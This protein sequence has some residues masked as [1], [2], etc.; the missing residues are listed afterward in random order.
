[1]YVVQFFAFKTQKFIRE[2][3]FIVL[4]VFF[5]CL[6]MLQTVQA[7]DPKVYTAED[8]YEFAK[9]Q[10]PIPDDANINAVV[11]GMWQMQLYQSSNGVT[12]L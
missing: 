12:L 9:Q 1:M 11:A 3:F 5:L 8:I 2:F 7:Q 4:L 10:Q 6:H